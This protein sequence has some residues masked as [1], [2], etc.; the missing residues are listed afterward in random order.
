MTALQWRP[1]GGEPTWANEITPLPTEDI[2]RQQLVFHRQLIP[3][4]TG[5]TAYTAADAVGGML[6]LPLFRPYRGGVIETVSI[7]DITAQKA[8]LIL[9]LF[10][11]PF[12]ATADNSAFAVADSAYLSGVATFTIAATDY[13]DSSAAAI[14]TVKPALYV[15][16]QTGILYGQFETS[17]T[18]TYAA[19]N[20]DLYILVTVRQF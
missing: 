12:T 10:E 15:A 8:A 14:G 13:A 3:R 1:E 17:G 6:T 2:Y 16:S 7:I 11:Q 18:P 20:Q 4:T 5:N 9:T 19:D